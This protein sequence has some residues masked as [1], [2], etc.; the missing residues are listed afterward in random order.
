VADATTHCSI[1]YNRCEN[2]EFKIGEESPD[3]IALEEERV[4]RR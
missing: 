2:R 3:G 4:G 1:A